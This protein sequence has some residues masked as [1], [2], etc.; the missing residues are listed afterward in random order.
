MT[1]SLDDYRGSRRHVLEWVRR[2]EFLSEINEMLGPTGAVVETTP[3]WMPKGV[4]DPA[5]ARI[6]TL[7]PGYLPADKREELRNWWLKHRAGANTPNWDFL[8]SCTIHGKR[9][10]VL[11]E[12]KA[13]KAELSESPKRPPNDA[14]ARSKENH[15]RICAAIDGASR[16]LAKVVPDISLS[17][18]THYQLANRIAFA[19]KLASMG[20]PVV[21][22]Y[23][24]FTGDQGIRGAFNDSEDWHSHFIEATKELFPSSAIGKRID[25]GAAPFW[26]LVKSRPALSESPQPKSKMARVDR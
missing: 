17:A 13:N 6:D 19:W 24:G 9:G 3:T 12:A 22:I 20:I 14:S 18:N 4:E 26:L 15:D 23:L 5:E 21:L 2:P 7:G 16:E 10:L 11:V 8:C 1:K 25:C